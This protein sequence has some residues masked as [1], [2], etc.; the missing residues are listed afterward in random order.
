MVFDLNRYIDATVDFCRS[1]LAAINLFYSMANGEVV[2][3]EKGKKVVKDLSKYKER[4]FT[5]RRALGLSTF[6][7]FGDIGFSYEGISFYKGIFISFDLTETNYIKGA[8]TAIRSFTPV[9]NKTKVTNFT[10]KRAADFEN[11]CL[12]L[13]YI[14][15]YKDAEEFSPDYTGSKEYEQTCKDAGVSIAG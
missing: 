2:E 7:P 11:A 5:E 6:T 13:A 4:L 8:E 12:I 14:E 15:M 3:E 1:Y 10:D 9:V